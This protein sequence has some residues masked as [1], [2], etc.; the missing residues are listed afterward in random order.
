MEIRNMIRRR[1]REI[2]VFREVAKAKGQDLLPGRRI[3]A[4]QLRRLGDVVNEAGKAFP[5]GLHPKA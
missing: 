4:E 2:K 3:L 5:P 1:A